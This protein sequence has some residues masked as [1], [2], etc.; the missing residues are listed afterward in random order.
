MF[1]KRLITIALA[2]LLVATC[3]A[4]SGNNREATEANNNQRPNES[5]SETHS[6]QSLDITEPTEE[7]TELAEST[8]P[9]KPAKPKTP[10]SSEPTIIDITS[11]IQDG[12]CALYVEIEQDVTGAEGGTFEL[13]FRLT[14]FYRD[15]RVISMSFVMDGYNINHIA[16]A[17]DL[18]IAMNA[19]MP[20]FMESREYASEGNYEINGTELTYSTVNNYNGNTVEYTCQLDSSGNLLFTW[21]APDVSRGGDGITYYVGTLKNGVVTYSVDFLNRD[22]S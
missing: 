10:E 11:Y 1:I 3:S 9:A 4:C 18:I 14:S 8:E 22:F 15:G 13:V 20:D 16:D 5:T 19:I 7:W 6:T 21:F 17:N 12:D 2:I